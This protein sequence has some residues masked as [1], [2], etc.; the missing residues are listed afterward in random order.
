MTPQERQL[1]DDLFD[2]LAKVE[3]APRDPDAQAVIADGQRRAPNAIYALVQTVLLQDEALRRAHE[4]ITE[5]EGSGAPE[6]APPGGFLDSMRDALFGGSSQGQ[7]QG[8]GQPRGSVPSVRPGDGGRPAW[9]TGQ[10]LGQPQQGGYGQPDPGQQ[11]QYGQPPMG[12]QAPQAGRGGSFLGTAA[13][14][15]AGMVGGSLLMNSLGGMFGGGSKQGFGDSANA[16]ESKSPWSSDSSGGDLAKDAG[17]NDIGNSSAQRSGNY[18]QAQADID[19]DQDQDQ[20]DMDMDS[21]FGD[22]DDSSFG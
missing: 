8:Q 11:G 20:D 17:V 4:R 12:Q 19:Q 10:V 3:A 1:V 22:D 14:A 16:S 13:A 21:D 15:A 9:N 2:R 6:Q 5:L 18:D 7:G